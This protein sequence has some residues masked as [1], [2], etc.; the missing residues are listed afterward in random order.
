MHRDQLCLGCVNC[1][2]YEGILGKNIGEVKK[3]INGYQ[4]LEYIIDSIVMGSCS[5]LNY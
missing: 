2:E 1:G 5:K 4:D 3:K